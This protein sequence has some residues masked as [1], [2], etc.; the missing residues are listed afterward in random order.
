MNCAVILARGGSKGCIGKN[1]RPLN[2]T[3]LVLRAVKTALASDV[4]DMVIV[5]SDSADILYM[6]CDVEGVVAVHRMP[7][8]DHQTSEAGL[9]NIQQYWKRYDNIALIQCTSPFMH[10]S[11]ISNT[12]RRMI[13]RNAG[14]CCAVTPFH[15]IVWDT[16]P[17]GG[18]LPR[19]Q[20]PTEWK[21]AGSVILDSVERL[22][23]TLF[24][25]KEAWK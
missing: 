2:G 17:T 4:C 7:V 14:S 10:P 18:R 19:Q 9:L 16:E 15:G 12:Y 25:R 5:A 13:A 24:Q 8:T 1:K 23:C 22:R 11:D 6:V 3:P 21:E 20:R